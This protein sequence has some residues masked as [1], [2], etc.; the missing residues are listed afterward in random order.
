MNIQNLI[1]LVIVITHDS[2][3]I[4]TVI[5]LALMSLEMTMNEDE[6]FAFIFQRILLEGILPDHK[7]EDKVHEIM[8]DPEFNPY[9]NPYYF[10]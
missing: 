2:I 3:S 5:Y 8:D 10:F 7:I 6:M 1:H 4:S 9:L